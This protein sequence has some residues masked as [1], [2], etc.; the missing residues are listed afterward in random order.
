MAHDVFIS[1]SSKDKP[2][3]DAVCA[4]LEGQRIR[5]WVAPRDVLPGL[6]YGEAIVDAIEASR[7]LVLVFSANANT[8][9]QVMREV[10]RAVSKGIPV[11]PLRIEAIR[12]SKSLELFISAPHWLDALTPPLAKHLQSLG[13]TVRLLL[14]RLGQRTDPAGAEP[15]AP[16]GAT[17]PAAGGQA[18]PSTRPAASGAGGSKPAVSGRRRRFFALGAVLLGL[19]G[20]A[21]GVAALVLSAPGTDTGRRAESPAPD[22]GLTSGEAPGLRGAAGTTERTEYP[23]QTK[24][25]SERTAIPLKPAALAGNW[26]LKLPDKQGREWIGSLIEIDVKDGKGTLSRVQ[27]DDV[28]TEDAQISADA[29]RFNQVQDE[30]VVVVTAFVPKGE[31]RPQSLRGTFQLGAGVGFMELERTDKKEFGPGDPHFKLMPGGE[32]LGN[33]LSTRDED[34]REK[35][36]KDVVKKF[37]DTVSGYAAA[38]ALLPTQVKVGAKDDELRALADCMQKVAREY[39]PLAEKYA[40]LTVAK[41]LTRADKMSPLA[42]EFARKAEKGL[43]KDAPLALSEA[44]LK[45]LV[46]ALTKAG[47]A[48]EAKEYTGAL[49]QVA[50]QLDEEFEKG[51]IPLQ[52][53]AYAGRKGKSSRVAVVELF[54]CAQ[55]WQCIPADIAFA[56]AIKTYKPTDVVLLEYHLHIPGFDPLTNA[57]AEG[58][59]R[60]YGDAIQGTPTAFVN[61]KQTD[62]LAGTRQYGEKGYKALC[63]TIDDALESDDRAGLMLTAMRKGDRIE[64]EASVSDLKKTG[65]KV[66][67]RFVLIED[68]ARYTGANG[69]RL[70][71]HVVRAFPGG[72]DGFAMKDAKASQ[73]VSLALGDVKQTLT[74]YLASADK[75]SPFPDDDR[76]LDLKHLKLVAL[77][78]DDESKEILQ[79]AQI[80]LPEE[81]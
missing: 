56:A 59:R 7:V 44:A 48:D 80:D 11:I 55:H 24:K 78:Q 81:K 71:H 47:Q 76:P 33:A 34:E 51:A 22:A 64:G 43:T 1:Y 57:D 14:S 45:T 40:V 28:R 79:A 10:E 16:A 67:L 29:V 6:P 70:H 15:E 9:P 68:V 25:E 38:E 72:I 3:A 49:A 31:E 23:A 26:R 74:D 36:L 53:A 32:A 12:P 46:S 8:S 39:G 20:A 77:I 75:K 21:V 73:K 62:P 5:C 69:R 4:T 66:R 27:G 42:V 61:G 17:E 58:R 2:V 52:P 50:A 18:E 65:E 19:L 30:G 37:G 13:E 63:K 41:A 60:Y 35:L 54:T